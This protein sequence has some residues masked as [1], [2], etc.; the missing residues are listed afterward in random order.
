MIA[1]VRDDAGLVAVHRTFLNGA[2]ARQAKFDN[3][4]RL[5]A[6]PETGA[7]RIGAANRVLGIA[8]GIETA[9]AAN[10]ITVS[11]YGRCSATNA[12]ASCRYRPSSNASSYSPTT[13]PAA[14]APRSWHRKDFDAPG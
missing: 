12:S 10:Q 5:L 11:R 3:P 1:A 6:V 13:T 2:T 8:E 4:K 9:L 7:V 14:H